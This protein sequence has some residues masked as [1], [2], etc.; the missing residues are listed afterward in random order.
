M[1]Q[2]EGNWNDISPKLREELEAQI[3]SFGKSVRFK[4]DIAR[5]NPDPQKFN[6][7][8]IY[9][10][11]YT[12][13]PKTF[14]I[15]DPYEDRPNKQK[16]KSIGIIERLDENDKPIFKCIRVQNSEKGVVTFNLENPDDA[17][18]AMYAL[19]HPK[20]GGG[21]FADKTKTQVFL[22]VDESSLAKEQ[23]EVRSVKLKALITAQKMSDKEVVEF[24]DAMMWDS[25]DDL[26]VLR[27]KVE[28]LAESTPELFN[29]LVSSKALE[30]QSYVKRALDSHI[31]SYEPVGSKF[32]WTSTTQ[33]IAIVDERLDKNHVEKM[34]EWLQTS[35]TKGDDVYKKI[36]S[37][38]K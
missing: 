8:T 13:D 36:K 6:G 31:I 1:L 23:K 16:V 26:L 33:A 28:E 38:L 19:L 37:L 17:E 21:K 24:A 14:K 22:R 18:K 29:D 30:I 10:F 34:A 35:G 32:S 11:I 3:V 27:N 2:Q 4:F 7:D 25:T 9:P 5:P 20:L 12:L 15:T